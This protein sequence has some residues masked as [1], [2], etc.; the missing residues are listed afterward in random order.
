MDYI[1]PSKI[2]IKKSGKEIVVLF[3]GEYYYEE[4][5]IFIYDIHNKYTWNKLR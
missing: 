3:Y 4:D 5:A 1:N 2:I